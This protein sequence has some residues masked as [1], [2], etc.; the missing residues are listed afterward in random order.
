MRQRTRTL[1]LNA[2]IA[3]P[4]G[5]IEGGGLL[6]DEHGV[7]RDI[8]ADGDEAAIEAAG[9]AGAVGKAGAVGA[10]GAGGGS[11]DG[12][13]DTVEADPGTTVVRNLG[14]R[15]VLPGLIDVH[16]HGGGGFEVLRGEFAQL[17]GMSRFHAAHGTTSFL[18]TLETAPPEQI[19][20]VLAATKQAAEAGVSGAELLGLHL[21]GPFLNGKRAGAQNTAHIIDPDPRLAERFL[22][23]ADGCIRLVTL[24][25]ELPGGLALASQF[26]A[27]GATVSAGHTDATYAEIE[28]AV[29]HG[30]T[31]MTHHFNGMRPFHHREPGAAG[32]GLLLPELTIELIADGFHVHP[33]AIR[34]AFRMKPSD[35]ICMVTDAVV[36]A[37]L[38][39]GEYGHSVMEGGRVYLKDRSSIAGSTLT[40][41]AALR[42]TLRFTGLPLPCVLPA[43]TSVPARQAGAAHRKGTLEAGKDADFIVVDEAY[44]L[45]MTVVRGRIVHQQ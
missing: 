38:P 7:I 21:E 18:A 45:Q 20:R 37:G 11:A 2:R 31:H 9:S 34:M 29:K 25:P 36:C 19:E 12:A 4:N 27:A 5:I 30:V 26:A 8:V 1:W 22:A 13:T 39:D 16:V 3:T 32:A 15:L 42:N 10:T 41:I 40:M 17:D 44:N 14:G 6:V 35:R 43:F 23:A 24:A 28:Q 33:E